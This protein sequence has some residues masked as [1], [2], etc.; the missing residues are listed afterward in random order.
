ME[1]FRDNFL[2]S[3][4]SCKSQ[5]DLI[6][7]HCGGQNGEYDSLSARL[8]SPPANTQLLILDVGSQCVPGQSDT[9]KTLFDGPQFKYVGVDM[10][11]GHNVDI[12][13]E[14]AYQW[15]EIEDNYCDVLISGQV[16]E[17]VE[18]PWFTITEM[19]R[20]VK[21]GG[22]I[23][24]IVPSMQSLHRYPVNCQNYFCDGVIALAKYAC[25]EIIHA[26]TN[27]AP[28]GAT[29]EWYNDN[30]QDT[31]LV[32]KK[33]DTWKKDGFDKL[34]YKLEPADLEIMATGL[35]PIEKQK[36]FKSYRM[37]RK[38]KK[39]TRIIFFPIT[40]ICWICKMVHRKISR[41]H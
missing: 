28:F 23:C 12:V 20:V 26:S 22:L 27:Y 36:W 11:D 8:P 24:I 32:A 34:S 30:V 15:N 4:A 1:W 6:I 19:A 33:P 39:Y 9:Y 37:R 3:R 21:P 5:C 14:N 31:I 41:N 17:H 16:L 40:F 38:I 25:L 10:I 35:V 7:H 29:R 2:L 13:V 18:F